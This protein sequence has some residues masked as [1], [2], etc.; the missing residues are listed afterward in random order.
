MKHLKANLNGPLKLCFC[1]NRKAE[2]ATVTG[3]SFNI[4]NEKKHFYSESRNLI[5]L[6]L[7]MNN[8][9][10][11]SY[12]LSNFCVDQ[13][14]MLADIAGQNSHRILWEK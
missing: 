6:K 8:Q 4:G 1:V 14:S 10:M 12:K 13:K 5:V 7:H 2:M 3:Y 9:W 11:V